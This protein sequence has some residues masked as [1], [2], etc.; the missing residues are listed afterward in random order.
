M[1]FHG[2]SLFDISR[3][4]SLTANFLF[5]GSKI[6]LPCSLPQQFLSLGCRSTV[7]MFLLGLGTM[8]S[9]VLWV[10]IH[11][12]FMLWSLLHREVSSRRMRT[13]T[14]CGYRINIEMA[15]RV[16]LQQRSGCRVSS[17]IDDFTRSH[18]EPHVLWSSPKYVHQ[19][20]TLGPIDRCHAGWC[21]FS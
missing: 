11:C 2:Y 12:S 9:P 14:I 7:F 17:K 16:M 1:R 18:H 6:F 20:Y 10:L 4:D 15:F 5:S 19:C 8:P 13:T 3:R 21:C